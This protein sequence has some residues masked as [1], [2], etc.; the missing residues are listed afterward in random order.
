MESPLVAKSPTFEKIRLTNP[1]LCP[2]GEQRGERRTQSR[3]IQLELPGCSLSAPIGLT[4]MITS[5]KLPMA[6]GPKY[7]P[8]RWWDEIPTE[9]ADLSAIYVALTDRLDLFWLD[10]DEIARRSGL[11]LVRV[12][13]ALESGL[14][15]GLIARHP[16]RPGLF[17]EIGFASPFL[18][19]AE[20]R[21]LSRAS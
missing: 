9:A 17:A 11:D 21:S 5:V 3:T 7:Q 18:A 16:S 13:S 12:R 4:A 6:A 15:D 19:A 14:R 10:E 20:L 1:K 2:N 8:R